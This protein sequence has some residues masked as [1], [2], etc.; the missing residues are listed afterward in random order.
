MGSGIV[1]AGL[2]GSLIA[3]VKEESAKKLVNHFA[4]KY[5][6]AKS[7]P[8]RAEIVSAVGGAGVLMV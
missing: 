4:E 5:Y 1:G 7:L 3:L 2:G 8:V 6:K